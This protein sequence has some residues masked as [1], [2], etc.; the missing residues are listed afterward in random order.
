[1]RLA[2]LLATRG[3]S[4]RNPERQ[5]KP[6]VPPRRTTSL[7]SWWSRNFCFGLLGLCA[8]AVFADDARVSGPVAGFVFDRPSQSIRPI[9]GV[10]GSSY[11]G[12]SV[13]DGFDIASVSPLGVSALATQS[14]KLFFIRNLNSG[15]PDSMPLDGAM[16]GAT[17][18]AWG[19]DGLNAAIYS[20]DSNQAQVLR[21]LDG[22]PTIEDPIDL[23][24]LNGPVTALAFDGKRLLIGAGGVYL[25]DGQ[26]AP[27]LLAQVANP[28]ALSLDSA[29]GD[30]YIADQANNQI[31]MVRGYA[32]D[33]TPML[34]ADE[35]SGVSSPVGTRVSADGLR[36]LIANSGSK[37]IDAVDLS[38][39]ATVGHIDLDFAPAR[40][41]ALGS[42]SLS[43]LNFGTADSPLYV[44]DSGGDL[45]VYFVPAGGGQ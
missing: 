43:L 34:F 20:A 35:R 15:Q 30:L 18:F 4:C 36:L 6:P 26:S 25:A 23:S 1:L 22:T 41:E 31:W 12:P 44:L 42:G 7:Q 16:S 9:F 3:R 45:A 19:S 8:L 27:K 2:S 38:T 10:P 24:L 39:R 17:M 40:M 11:L 33:V 29:K 14:G 13:V 21:N 37:G 28:V 5:A 32:G